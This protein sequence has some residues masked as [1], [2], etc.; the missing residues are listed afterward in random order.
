MVF[1]HY[2]SLC[3]KI[4]RSKRGALVGILVSIGLIGISS[5]ALVGYMQGFHKRATI[6]GTKNSVSFNIHSKVLSHLQALLVET[7]VDSNREEQ[8]KSIW[9][10]CSFLNPTNKISG[11]ESL[12]FNIGTNLTAQSKSSFSRTRWQNFFDKNEYEISVSDEPCQRIDSSFQSSYFGRCFKYIGKAKEMANEIYVIGRIVPKDFLSSSPIDLSTENT[13][14]PKRVFFELQS[15]VA[16]FEGNSEDDNVVLPSK[17]FNIIWANAVTECHV[18]STGGPWTV[19]QFSGSG[20]GRLSRNVVINSESFS[21]LKT[22]ND[23]VFND[24]A[25]HTITSYKILEDGNIVADHSSNVR[26]ACR[27]KV[28]KC[29]GVLAHEDEHYDPIAFNVGLSNETG[30]VLNIKK[31]KMDFV[32]ADLASSTAG[33]QISSLK[34]NFSDLVTDFETNNNLTNVS[35][36]PGHSVYRFTI[37]KKDDNS[38]V[39]F[40]NNICSGSGESK[41]PLITIDLKKPPGASCTSYSSKYSDDKYRLRCITCHSKI[42]S[43]DGVGAF[44]PVE[45][46]GDVQGLVDE[47]LDGTLP[48]CT[49]P[50]EKEKY[51]LPDI[52]AGSGHCVAMEVSN[53]D[54]F[55]DFESAS[56]KFDS[57]NSQLPVLCFA[58]GHYLPAISVSSPTSKPTLFKGSFD[59]A[60]EA[61][62]KM[63]REIVKKTSLASYFQVTYS[64]VLKESIESIVGA[65]NLPV[66]TSDADYFDYINNASRGIFLVPK[67]DVDKIS[68]R[69]TKGDSS[70]FNKFGT[71]YN[72]IWVAIEKDAGKQV[73]GSIPQ[74]VIANSSSAIFVRQQED[75]SPRPVLLRNTNSV[76]NSGTKAVLTHNI[77]HK[78][79]MTVDNGNYPV[80][81]R[82]DYGDFVLVTDNKLLEEAINAC[83]QEGAH[84]LPPVSSLEWIKAMT[85]LNNNSEMYPF[86]DPGD[87]SGDNYIHSR[88]ISAPKVWVGLSKA[89]SGTSAQDYRLSEG[90]FPDKNGKKS[91]FH[92]E[93]QEIPAGSTDYVGIIDEKGR[94]VVPSL[95]VTFFKDFPFSNYR[96]ACYKNKGGN[97]QVELEASVSADNSCSHQSI[98][99]KSDID[100]KR[101]SIRFMSEW[102]TLYHESPA[103]FIIEKDKV[104]QLVER[105]NNIWCKKVECPGC[106]SDCESAASSCRSSCPTLSRTDTDDECIANCPPGDSCDCTTTHYYKDPSCVSDC[107][108]E[109]GN[110]I[111]DCLTCNGVEKNSCDE[112]CDCEHDC[113][114]HP[115][116][117]IL[118]YP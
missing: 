15:H 57:C 79:V 3:V 39:N 8:E 95:K 77:Q 88:S 1:F 45:N 5:A 12:L 99:S 70:Y 106:K 105:A 18:Q 51:E 93:T 29:P 35:L 20:A 75:V 65:L 14:D 74:A 86:P 27:R 41:F 104:N 62:Y 32:K 90:H 61:C 87:L 111:K 22:C 24:I 76:S 28:Y 38:L 44:G 23:L 9:G 73:I 113:S 102:V 59:Q 11:V 26:T 13:L 33:S 21:D 47:P 50:S 116:T 67:Y 36:D 58:Y 81:C 49:L 96:K 17:Q 16:V 52:N 82:K 7:R 56:Y 85:L 64:D 43:R 71:G 98:E 109:K 63:G 112:K 37:D 115:W 100:T 80:L 84:F 72:K 117:D 46:E 114:G 91:I 4:G 10:V 101:K 97:D 83:K 66:S 2:F 42:C 19:V 69:L 6:V 54:S 94:P 30:S 103:E 68:K 53:L 60:Q 108:T 40:C 31:V 89:G 25:P 55:K 107:D 118:S 48:E 110:C 92:F 34:V 78:G